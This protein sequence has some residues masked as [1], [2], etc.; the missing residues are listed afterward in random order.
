MK[1]YI[2]LE[3]SKAQLKFKFLF[4]AQEASR[5]SK[6]FRNFPRAKI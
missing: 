1:A 3:A 4:R 5:S 6:A 2:E